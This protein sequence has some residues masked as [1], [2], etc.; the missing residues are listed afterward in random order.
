MAP[1]G[2]IS[3]GIDCTHCSVT[4]WVWCI[5]TTPNIRQESVAVVKQRIAGNFNFKVLLCPLIALLFLVLLDGCGFHLRGQATLPPE[6]AVTYIQAT[7]ANNRQPSPLIAT[8]RRTLTANGVQITDS[9]ET[10]TAHLVILDENNR[11]R[12]LATGEAGAIREYSLEYLVEFLVKRPQGEVLISRQQVNATGNILYDET[13]VLGRI[14]GEQ[15]T[16]RELINDAAAS[17]LRRIQALS[18][19]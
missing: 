16:L 4:S 9:P 11:R 8:L 13:Q 12:T 14:A 1:Q 5:I 18:A 7:T 6:M 10:A 17:I 19:A 2:I 15:I 3:L